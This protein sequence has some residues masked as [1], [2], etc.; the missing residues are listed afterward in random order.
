VSAVA[1]A[2]ILLMVPSLRVSEIEARAR[3]AAAVVA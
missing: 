3:A 2:L 1:T